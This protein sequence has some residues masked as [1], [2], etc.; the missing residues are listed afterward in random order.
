MSRT[1]TS[2]PPA[3]NPIT[4]HFYLT[5]LPCPPQSGCHMCITPIYII[6]VGGEI[7]TFCRHKM[8]GIEWKKTQGFL[9]ESETNSCEVTRN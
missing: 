3:L 5:P 6:E 1:L 2:L 8:S 9:K 7:S 4:S